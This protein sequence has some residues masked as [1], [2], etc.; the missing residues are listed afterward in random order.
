MF[1]VTL[2]YFVNADIIYIV[3]A[4]KHYGKSSSWHD[5]RSRYY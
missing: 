3:D 1:K 2:K 4:E 5:T